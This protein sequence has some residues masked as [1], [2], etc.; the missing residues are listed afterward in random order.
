MAEA[1]HA[2]AVAAFLDGVILVVE[3]GRTTIDE[4]ATA[5]RTL[6]GARANVLGIVLNKG[7]G[8]SGH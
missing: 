2:Q 8:Q 7:D 6:E 4:V 5:I 3:C 1:P